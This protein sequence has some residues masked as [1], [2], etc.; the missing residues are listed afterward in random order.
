[1]FTSPNFS[2]NFFG[3]GNSTPNLNVDDDDNFNMNYNRVK[4]S[5]IK[6]SPSLHWRGDF[7]THIKFLLSY[8]SIEVE[9]TADRFINTFYVANGE[10]NHKFFIGSELTYT[11]KNQDN[12]AFPTL[13]MEFDLQMGY[14]SNL[15]ASKSF[16]YVIPSLAFDYKLIP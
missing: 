10:E 6:L 1:D 7:G 12:K 5:T 14:K 13:G 15:E 2:V 3:F 8:E 4:L 16:G 9:K 11:Y